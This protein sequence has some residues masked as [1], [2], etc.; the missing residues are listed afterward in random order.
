MAILMTGCAFN[1]HN[2]NVEIDQAQI[3]PVIGADSITLFLRVLD[4]REETDLGRRGAGI[5]VAKVEAEGL[6]PRFTRAVEEGF[7]S[8]GYSLTSDRTEADAELDV[9][10]RTLRFE[11]SAGFFTVGAEADATIL[12]EAEKGSLDYRNQYR[13]SDEDRQLAVSFGGGIDEQLSLVM[14]EVLAQLFG[15]SELDDFLLD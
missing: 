1:A 13:F 3:N 10:L 8:K 14:N 15:D 2:A 6:I 12:A 7:V 5:G 9:I 4:E 11:E